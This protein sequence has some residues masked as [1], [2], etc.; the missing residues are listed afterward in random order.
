MRDKRY[1]ECLSFTIC[2]PINNKKNTL[3]NWQTKQTS[4]RLKQLPAA[5]T[6]DIEKASQQYLIY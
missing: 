2:Q 1:M 3:L 6:A 4:R 5:A